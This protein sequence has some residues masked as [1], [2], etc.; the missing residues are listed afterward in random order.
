MGREAEGLLDPSE[1]GSPVLAADHRS[2]SRW[3]C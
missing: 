1:V 2:L 3:L